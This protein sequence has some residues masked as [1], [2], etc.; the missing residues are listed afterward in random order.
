[1]NML[2]VEQ[3][4]QQATQL[5]HDERLQLIEKLT[6]TVYDEPSSTQTNPKTIESAC[7]ILQAPC[8]V[9]LEQKRIK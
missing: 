7:S 4:F 5:S 2:T 9:S 1:M 8:H 6:E 3:V